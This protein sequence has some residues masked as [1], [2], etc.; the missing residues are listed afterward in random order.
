MNTMKSLFAAVA[1]LVSS[2]ALASSVTTTQTVDA[3]VSPTI[4]LSIDQP[5]ATLSLTPG[6]NS[7]AAATL[8]VNSTGSYTIGAQADTDAT[9]G[10]NADKLFEW[11]TTLATPAY[12]TSGKYVNAAPTV[13]GAAGTASG[14]GATVTITT[15]AQTIFTGSAATSSS[16]DTVSTSFVE[17][18]PWGT[19]VLA[20]G[21][22]YHMVV[23]YTATSTGV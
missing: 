20:T 16:G 13:T 9:K 4:T 8:T 2:V 3:T 11:D 5:T 17:A 7:T 15:S 14:T 10:T 12:V 22:K 21:H 23:T 18:T 6:T 1:L 19:A